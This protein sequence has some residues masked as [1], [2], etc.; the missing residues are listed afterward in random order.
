M[1]GKPAKKRILEPDS[2]FGSVTVSKLINY[3]MERGKKTVAARI[4][5]NALDQAAA[6]LK[7]QPLIVLE[8]AVKNTSPLIEV[9]SHRIGGANYQVPIEVSK[10]RRLALSLRWIIQ[11]AKSK[12]GQQM[13]A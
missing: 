1:R 8:Q 6:Q 12:K 11:A 3:V 13:S 10:N 4:T 9:R 2:K 5:Y 7:S